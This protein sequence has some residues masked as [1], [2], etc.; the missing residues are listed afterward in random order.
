LARCFS[1]DNHYDNIALHQ[2][3]CFSF[4]TDGFKGDIILWCRL[5]LPGTVKRIY[6]LQSKALIKLFARLLCEDENAMLEDLEQGDVAQTIQTFYERNS[7]IKPNV[8]S[9]L[10]LQEV[11]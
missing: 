9:E 4:L 5:L 1:I 2:Y 8:T 6:N 10:T 7:T 3:H 11:S